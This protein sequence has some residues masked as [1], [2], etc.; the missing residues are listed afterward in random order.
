MRSRERESE[1]I[2]WIEINN[3]NVCTVNENGMTGDEYMDWVVDIHG[4]LQIENG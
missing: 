4:M 3:C 1:I 2:D